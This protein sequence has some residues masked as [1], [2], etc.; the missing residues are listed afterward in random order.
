LKLYDAIIIGGGPA[1]SHTAYKLAEK[2]HKIMVLERKRRVGDPVCCAGI[3]GQEC[4]STFAIEDKVILRQVNSASL[5]SPSGNRLSLWREKPQ[6]CILD[7]A[8]LD[9]AMAARAQ[10]AGAEYVLN[11]PAENIVI[12]KDRVS[13]GASRQGKESTFATRAVVIASGFN[14]ALCERL[15]L[16]KPDDF[17]TGAQAEVET[18]GISEVEVYFG[19]EIAPDF[20][21]WLVPTIPPMARVGLMSRKSPGL[22]LRKWL[23]HLAAQ[24]KIVTP[25]AELS[26]GGI[27]LKPLPRTCGE[28]LLVIGDAAGQ[29]KPTNGGGIY[30]GLLCAD[31]AARTLHQALEDGDLSAKRLTR[32]ERAWRKRLGRE[33][34][35]GYWARKL[36]E[37]LSDRQIDRIFEIAKANG[38]DEAL[39]K[40]EDLPFDWHSKTVLRLMGYRMVNKAIGVIKLPFRAG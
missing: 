19:R 22:H 25:E 18:A 31:M 26:Y 14:S 17:T 11:S 15:G 23:A 28:R 21:A 34:R 13:V 40:A 3:I 35:I 2:G 20:F 1:G 24:G 27:P 29:V 30:Y 9:M 7:R 32:Y 5:F 8:S 6:A 10:D 39:L 33:L 4:A 16:G 37:H 38:I 12:E 36:F